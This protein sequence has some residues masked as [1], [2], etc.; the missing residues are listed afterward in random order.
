MRYVGISIMLFLAASCSDILDEQPRSIYEPGF[1]KTEKGLHGG[2]TSMY[3]HLRYIYGQAY[4][5]NACQTGT[6]ETTYAQQADA[7]FKDM[8]ISL[9]A[10]LDEKATSY[11]ASEKYKVE[12][13]KSF[14][15]KSSFVLYILLFFS[16]SF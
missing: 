4:Y 7:N 5:Y 9:W 10:A 14:L 12:W 6:D 16:F 13:E 15:F 3:A 2:L 11:L 8:D 1:F